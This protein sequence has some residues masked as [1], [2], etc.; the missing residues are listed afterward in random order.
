MG[1]TEENSTDSKTSVL[2]L[3]GGRGWVMSFTYILNRSSIGNQNEI[4]AKLILRSD[5]VNR[6]D[7]LGPRGNVRRN[8]DGATTFHDYTRSSSTCLTDVT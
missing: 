7:G 2:D 4:K 5:L 1:V 8:L 6:E 3:Y